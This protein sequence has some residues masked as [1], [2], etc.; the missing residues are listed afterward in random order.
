MVLTHTVVDPEFRGRGIANALAQTA[1][2]NLVTSGTGR[3][4]PGSSRKNT[5]SLSRKPFRRLG[6]AAQKPG[7]RGLS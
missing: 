6:T 4:T 7:P 2:D 5:R 3:P 1:L